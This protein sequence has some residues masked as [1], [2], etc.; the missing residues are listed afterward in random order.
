MSL[1]VSIPEKND[2]GVFRTQLH[3]P[4]SP[5]EPS[6]TCRMGRGNERLRSISH[7]H[8]SDASKSGISAGIRVSGYLVSAAI[9]PP[10]GQ[11]FDIRIVS[12][13]EV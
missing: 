9:V 4:T 3:L 1:N 13:I 7:S 12:V 10:T 8:S 2:D 11:L 5:G 6:I